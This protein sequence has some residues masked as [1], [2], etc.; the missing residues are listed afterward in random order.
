MRV[1]QLTLGLCG[2]FGLVM[3]GVLTAGEGV[4][5]DMPK[6]RRA[7]TV[8]FE[9]KADATPDQQASLAGVTAKNDLKSARKLHGKITQAQAHGPQLPAEELIAG[10]LQATG[11]VAFAEPDYGCPPAQE[12][13]AE[14]HGE[15]A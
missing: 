10:E 2:I 12:R 1:V 3:P 5:K 15:G 6:V 4:G 9:L 13:V 11:A 14:Q 7:G 8:L